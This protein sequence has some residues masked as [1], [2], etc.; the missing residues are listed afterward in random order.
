M[1]RLTTSFEDRPMRERH[2]PVD[3]VSRGHDLLTIAE[4]A[5]VLRCSKAGVAGATNGDELL[6]EVGVSFPD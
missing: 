3:D 1:S 6:D 4:L 2:A 5:A